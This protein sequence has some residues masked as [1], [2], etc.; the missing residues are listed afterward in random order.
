M[1][2]EKEMEYRVRYGKE[3]GVPMT[4]YG[5]AIAQIHGILKRSLKPFPWIETENVQR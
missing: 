5:I 2:N 3:K 1:L 4:N